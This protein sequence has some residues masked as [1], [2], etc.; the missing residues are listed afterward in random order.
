MQTKIAHV[1][2]FLVAGVSLVACG[3]SERAGSEQAAAIADAVRGTQTAWAL[4]SPPTPAVAAARDC[5]VPTAGTLLLKDEE[6]GYCLLYPEGHGVLVPYPGEVEVIP[7]DPPYI[8][9]FG[10]SLTVNVEGADGRT[11]EQVADKVA[12]EMNCSDGP[13]DLTIAGEKAVVW[14]E[15][16][17]QDRTRR[18]YMIHADRL[19]TLAFVDLSDRFYTLVVT[20]FTFLR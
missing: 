4:S 20:S 3:V 10:A 8:G 19:Y 12:V 6:A 16:K 14:S 11:A 5:P 2:S 9:S 17:G 13:Y 15:C 18:V 1:L 7:G